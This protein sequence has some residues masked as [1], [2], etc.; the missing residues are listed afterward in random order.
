MNGS[1]LV[2]GVFAGSKKRRCVEQTR[3]VVTA[4]PHGGILVLQ[5]AGDRLGEVFGVGP[6]RV[7][8]KERAANTQIQDFAR[9]C[10]QIR[11]ED[12]SRAACVGRKPLLDHF[13]LWDGGQT[14]GIAKS[15]VSKSRM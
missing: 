12:G 5:F 3:L 9:R 2:G 4:N 7:S 6:A 11:I 8:A 1:A 14:A 13:T 15:V 10:M